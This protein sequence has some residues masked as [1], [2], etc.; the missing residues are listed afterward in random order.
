LDLT[1]P[2]T[3]RIFI[4]IND[5]DKNDNADTNNNNYYYAGPCYG[6]FYPKGNQYYS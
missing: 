4:D 2:K 6:T 1:L 3:K 5:T